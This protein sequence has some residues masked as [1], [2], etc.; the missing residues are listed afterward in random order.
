MFNQSKTIYSCL[1]TTRSELDEE[2]CISLDLARAGTKALWSMSSSC[3]N[4]DYMRKH[5]TVPL[6]ARL[7]KTIHIDIAIPTMGTLQQCATEPAFQLAIQTEGMI[8]DIVHHLSGDNNELKVQTSIL[9]V[10][11]SVCLIR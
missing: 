11:S 6:F 5:G 9:G 10:R 1:T 4:R 8:P 2:E 3:K 7:L